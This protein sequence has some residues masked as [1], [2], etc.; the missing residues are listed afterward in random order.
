MSEG[1]SSRG[2]VLTPP[3]ITNTA[4]VYIGVVGG[5]AVIGLG[6]L[7][8]L[9]GNGPF[10]V[11]TWWHDLMLRLRIDAGLAI[12]EGLQAVGNTIPMAVVTLV[13]VVALLVRR[14]LRPAVTIAAAV[15]LAELISVVLK[16]AIARPRPPDSLSTIAATS[17]PSG[18]TT[19]A[20]AL[21]V[22]LVLLLRR[23][24]LW[25]IAVAW[26]VAMA[27]SRTYLEAHW[28][29]DVLAGAVLGTSAACLAWGVS[30]RFR[31]RAG[32]APEP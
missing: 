18:H 15:L 14:R 8:L 10:A 19:M 11:D 24:W 1:A 12:A 27:W 31:R 20:A 6:A 4:A 25:I 17:Y 13:I 7:L 30:S 28:L 9:L 29:T 26:I 32:G 16:A 2:P 3:T 23:R 22:I 5:A 21:T